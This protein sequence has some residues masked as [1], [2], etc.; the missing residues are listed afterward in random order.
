[1]TT[2]TQSIHQ[3]IQAWRGQRL[4]LVRLALSIPLV[5]FAVPSRIKMD[6]TSILKVEFVALVRAAQV[7]R[8][9]WSVRAI[10]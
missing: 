5:L 10:I 3:R 8:K 1:M 4:H 6:I 2:Q 7:A 9:G